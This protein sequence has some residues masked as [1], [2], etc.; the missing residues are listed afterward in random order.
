MP[1]FSGGVSVSQCEAVQKTRASGSA[2]PQI[3]RQPMKMRHSRDR[4]PGLPPVPEPIMPVPGPSLPPQPEPGEPPGE[5][6][7]PRPGE[8]IPRRQQRRVE[9]RHS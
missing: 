6:P 2:A 1:D 7:P 5:P 8:P 3:V 4:E 9:S